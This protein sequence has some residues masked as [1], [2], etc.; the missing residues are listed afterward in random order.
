MA[1]RLSTNKMPESQFLPSFAW[2]NQASN[3]NT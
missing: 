1:L 3:K 2:T